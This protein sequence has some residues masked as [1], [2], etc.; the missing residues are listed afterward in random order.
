MTKRERQRHIAEL[1]KRY[2][3]KH[4][5]IELQDPTKA[6]FRVDARRDPDGRWVV[7]WSS[8]KIIESAP[9]SDHLTYAMA[10]HEIGHCAAKAACVSF[11]MYKVVAESTIDAEVAAWEWAIQN[12]R[13]PIDMDVPAR[14]LKTY[15]VSVADLRP[16]HPVWRLIR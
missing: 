8:D 12:A 5:R 4:K 9:I 7:D 16:T 3:I 14:C 11:G 10:L 2:E 15:T 1:C 6:W 13:E